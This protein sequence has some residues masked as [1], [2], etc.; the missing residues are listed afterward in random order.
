MNALKYI[1][2]ILLSVFLF[3]SC[4]G[5]LDTLPIDDNQLV[6]DKLYADP[7]NYKGVLAK[8]YASLILPG[9]LGP[10][11]DNDLGSSF[12]EGY[13]GYLRAL[14]YLQELTTDV[15]L[16]PSATNGL[17]DCVVT[18]WTPNTAVIRGCYSRLYTNIGYCNEFLRQTTDNMLQS[19]GVANDP[20]IKNN[21]PLYRDEARFIRAY[22]YTV[23][24][25]LFGDIPF[26]TD[27][28]RVGNLPEQKSRREIFDYVE[29]ELSDLSLKLKDPHQNEYGRVDKA[30]AWLLLS[31]LYLNAQVYVNADRNADAY[32]YAK[33]VIDAGFPLAAEY[34]YNFMADNDTSPEIIWPLVQDGTNT[35]TQT[36]ANF[37]V[38]AFY[39]GSMDGYFTTGIG[40]GGWSNVRVRPEFVNKFEDSDQTFDVNDVWG[41]KKKDKRAQFFTVGHQ[42]EVATTS[43]QFSTVFTDGYAFIKWRNVRK[44]EQAAG[45]AAYAEIDIPLFRSAD[46]YLMAA[47]AILRNGGGTRTEALGYVNEVR[48]R[49][50]QSGKYGTGVSGSIND[51]Q[52]T[53][54]FLLDER[55]RE[56]STELVRRT[57]LIRFG[58]F[59]KNYNWSWKGNVLRGK[60]VDDKYLL[61]PIP[62]SDLSANPNL[63][64]NS[65]YK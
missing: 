4:L 52:L 50:Y 1:S 32:R 55:A 27:E 29:T 10:S 12:D 2:A 6:A 54:D 34:R 28:N 46:A 47:E 45:I 48:N 30:A 63:V 11:G 23:L 19:R 26:V 17:R 44:D 3:S 13:G 38:R 15:I 14:F 7:A 41:T 64:Q 40:A 51:N 9:Q 35:Q 20:E 57:D 60:D 58:K 5:D 25:D 36:G 22:Y 16:M 56:L 39:S 53:L 61:F 8:C 37:F 33:M 59:T 43:G 21:L 42:K 62:E 24:C 65:D 49:A 31:R 18:G